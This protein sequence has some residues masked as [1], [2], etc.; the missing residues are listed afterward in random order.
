MKK[1][2][3]SLLLLIFGLS[4]YAQQAECIQECRNDIQQLVQKVDSLEHQLTYL[5]LCYELDILHLNIQDSTNEIYSHSQSLQMNVV[6][7]YYRKKELDSKTE[8]YQS[9]KYNYIKKQELFDALKEFY[10]VSK[11][12]NKFSDSEIRLLN[13]R[14]QLIENDFDVLKSNMYLFKTA[15]EGYADL[16]NNR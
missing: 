14:I 3:F 5:N 11:I 2:I 9:F 1:I 7:H 4:V 10:M 6:A 13:M 8:Y 12:A 15:I 16:I